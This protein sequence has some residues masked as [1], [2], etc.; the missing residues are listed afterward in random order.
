[1]DLIPSPYHAAATA[2]SARPLS[3]H[4]ATISPY[5]S[6]VIAQSTGAFVAPPVLAVCIMLASATTMILFFR[7]KP[8]S[9]L[10]AEMP[11]AAKLAT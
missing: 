8:L 6:G 5:L 9:E 11:A 2:R 7:F 1:M 4:R 3:H 10:V